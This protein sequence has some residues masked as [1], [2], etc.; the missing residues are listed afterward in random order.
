MFR[1][2]ADLTL[3][4]RTARAGM[5]LALSISNRFFHLYTRAGSC[6]PT[7]CLGAFD[8]VTVFHPCLK[9]LR[10]MDQIN[11]TASNYDPATDDAWLHAHKQRIKNHIIQLMVKVIIRK[12]A[13]LPPQ[14]PVIVEN[15]EQAAKR[16]KTAI[17]KRSSAMTMSSFTDFSEGEDD[18]PL[19]VPVVLSPTELA[20]SEFNLYMNTK[21]SVSVKDAVGN[22][23]GLIRYWNSTGA[24]DYPF[25]A[26]VA[27]CQLGT[28]AGSGV[29]ENDFS[30]FANLVTRHRSQLDPGI[31]EMI[32]FCK[33][34]SNLIP[35][36]IP[37][38]SQTDIINHIPPKLR[39]PN[40]QRAVQQLDIDPNIEDLDADD[41][42]IEEENE[43]D[44]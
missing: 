2:D 35:P 17:F 10:F 31:V 44:S 24:A 42:H 13:D 11:Q 5:N 1:D 4:G 3:I 20:T 26:V 38:I 36:S 19:P 15:V 37:R 39:D 27:L 16:Q 23:D 22:P 6:P 14:V 41:E 28:P 7:K 9:K 8:I 34:N 43:N 25:L 29:L 30:T 18:E 33:L 32:L 12:E 40:M 21:V